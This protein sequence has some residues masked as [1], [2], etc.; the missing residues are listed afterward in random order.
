MTEHKFSNNIAEITC[1]KVTHTYKFINSHFNTLK[2]LPEL[3]V[4]H[5]FAFIIAF[6]LFCVLC[7][8]PNKENLDIHEFLHILH[9][10]YIINVNYQWY[11]AK[12]MQRKV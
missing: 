1:N 12:I 2:V 5:N 3:N 9:I 10:H 8:I 7:S 11:C 6:F 4:H